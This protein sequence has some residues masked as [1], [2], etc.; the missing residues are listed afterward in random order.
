MPKKR[1]KKKKLSNFW[2]VTGF[3]F[4]FAWLALMAGGAWFLFGPEKTP[5]EKTPQTVIR[6]NKTAKLFARRAEALLVSPPFDK[7][8]QV[9]Y[10]GTRS[11][12]GG[13]IYSI[14]YLAKNNTVTILAEKAVQDEWR[15][16]SE[17]IRVGVLYPDHAKNGEKVRMVAGTGEIPFVEVLLKTEKNETPSSGMVYKNP[18]VDIKKPSIKKSSGKIVIII[19]DIGNDITTL[20]RLLDI[21]IPI[22]Y[23]VLPNEPNVTESL[24]ILEESGE[25][26]MLHMPMQPLSYP[27]ADP[28]EGSLFVSMTETEIKQTMEETINMVPGAVGMNNHMGSAF[29]VYA[30]GM[31]TALSV[32]DENGLFF[33]D[34]RTNSATIGCELAREM[35]I[36]TAERKIFL[37]HE[38]NEKSIGA[39]LFKLAEAAENDGIAIGIGHPYP[40]TVAVL[41]KALPLLK[42]EGYSFV[43]AS[44]AVK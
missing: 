27:D 8:G 12:S 2:I 36:R 42:S 20:K 29:T 9:T 22:T 30:D 34:S 18:P 14:T 15:S 16:L 41:E 28:G 11:H 35:G 17:N 24:S 31:K 26:I 21:N 44:E 37:D 4:L 6:S 13:E 25:E 39:Q 33:I 5:P 40:E 32:L 1:R 7:S 38:V 19:D 23:A 10:S 3:L 43:Y